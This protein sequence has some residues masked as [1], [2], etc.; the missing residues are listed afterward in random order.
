MLDQIIFFWNFLRNKIAFRYDKTT[1]IGWAIEGYNPFTDNVKVRC[2]QFGYVTGMKTLT[3]SEFE[4]L[5]TL[6]RVA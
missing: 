6:A 2:S 5:P 1:G 4:N 3:R